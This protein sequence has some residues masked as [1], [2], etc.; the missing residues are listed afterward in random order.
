M[1]GRYIQYHRLMDMKALMERAE[2]FLLMAGKARSAVAVVLKQVVKQESLFWLAPVGVL[3]AVVSFLSALPALA[4]P[5]VQVHFSEQA[6]IQFLA[7]P[8]SE[9]AALVAAAPG[10]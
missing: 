4:E 6:V 5:V 2:Y 9:P 8:V 1:E 10:H 7:V 3:P